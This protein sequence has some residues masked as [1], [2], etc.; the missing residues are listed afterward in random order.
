MP[1]ME[2]RV[3]VVTGGGGGIGG[4]CA[5]LL[6]REGA[7]TVITDLNESTLHATAETI[8]REG[9]RVLP[10][11]Q[12]VGEESAWERLIQRVDE[13]WGPPD[14]LVNNAGVG[15]VDM[16]PDITLE[17]WRELMRVNVEGVFL[18]MKHCAPLMAA[19]GGG[20]IVNMSSVAGITGA[21]GFTLYG[22]S[23]GA[24][25]SMTKDV[26][27]EY[28]EENVR[29]NSVHP[30][31]IDTPMLEDAR[32]LGL[33]LEELAEEIHPLGKLGQPEDVAEA[34]LFLASERSRMITG[35]ELV[36]DGGMTAR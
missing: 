1:D 34:V 26:A 35:I 9:G 10:V 24:V 31:L 18:G 22:A 8:E 6:A 2:D 23:K 15:T 21:P 11:Q 13:Q 29:V 30:G 27:V 5:R 12:D 36:V 4:A 3:A 32:E 17:D 19:H 33:S 20:S 28:A 25:R 7:A 14:V 16:L